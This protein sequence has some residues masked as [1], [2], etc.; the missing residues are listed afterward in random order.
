MLMLQPAM[1]ADQQRQML[2][3]L[4]SISS[5]LCCSASKFESRFCSSSS[6]DECGENAGAYG[7]AC[8]TGAGRAVGKRV[9]AFALAIAM[10]NTTILATTCTAGENEIMGLLRQRE[11]RQ[12]R[13]LVS[14]NFH[15]CATAAV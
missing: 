3:F 6:A 7:C 15:G 1:T 4:S 8:P 2:S 5:S 14:S 10:F 11:I 12:Q 9:C 13:R